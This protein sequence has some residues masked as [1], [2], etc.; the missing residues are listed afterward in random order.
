MQIVYLEKRTYSKQ[1]IAE[2]LDIK[3]DKNFKRNVINKLTNLGFIENEDFLYKRGGDIVILYVPQTYEEKIVYLVRLLG[4][5]KRIDPIAFTTFLYYLTI[6]SPNNCNKMPWEERAQWLHDNYN[7]NVSEITLKRWIKKLID[8]NIIHKDTY[9]FEYWCT[10]NINGNRYR[11]IVTTDEDKQQMSEY[12]K[13][14]SLIKKEAKDLFP[15][16]KKA[17]G[18]YVFDKIWQKY[19]CKYYKCSSFVFNAWENNPIMREI[20]DLILK[21]FLKV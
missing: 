20:R 12:W 10:V 2:I 8:L 15:I 9:N 5:D 16:D 6:D 17:C 11:Y 4:I 3:I 18:E 1:E 21:K 13:T 19:H 7:I 14:Y